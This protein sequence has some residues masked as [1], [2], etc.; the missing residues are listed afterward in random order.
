MSRFAMRQALTALQH[1]KRHENLMEAMSIYITD[2]AIINL[3]EDLLRYKNYLIML[4]R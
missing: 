2:K 3:T 4:M 1:T